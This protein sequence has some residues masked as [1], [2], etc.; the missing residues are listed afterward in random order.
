MDKAIAQK[1]V[2]DRF[3]KNTLVISHIDIFRA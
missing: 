2:S 1:D 3:L